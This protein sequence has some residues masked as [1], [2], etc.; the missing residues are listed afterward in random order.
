LCGPKGEGTG[1]GD[2]VGGSYN[3]VTYCHEL[4]D[5]DLSAST[6]SAVTYCQK[7]SW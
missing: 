3:C 2:S 1:A 6:G 7:A 5:M 4:P